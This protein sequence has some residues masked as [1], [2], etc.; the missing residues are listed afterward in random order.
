MR[1]ASFWLLGIF[2]C[3]ITA[4]LAAGAPNC[5]AEEAAWNRAR[6]ASETAWKNCQAAWKR[7]R[8]SWQAFE[9]AK[10][11][12]QAASLHLDSTVATLKEAHAAKL[13]C[14]Q[15]KGRKGKC[16]AEQRAE[17]AAIAQVKKAEAAYQA[18]A[19]KMDATYDAY[20]N[21]MNKANKAYKQ[22]EDAEKKYKAAVDA[23]NRCL[24]QQDD[25]GRKRAQ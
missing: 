24:N 21:D 6:A 22:A 15:I 19:K 17:N 23:L 16:A 2:L 12:F 9:S 18:A 8:E 5:Q 1:K 4:S 13:Q 11:Q 10:D 25:Q 3:G 20:T 14:L 7:A